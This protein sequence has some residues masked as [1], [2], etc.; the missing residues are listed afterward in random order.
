M[1][2]A[3]SELT[4]M[5]RLHE[6]LLAQFASEKSKSQTELTQAEQTIRTAKLQRESRIL[7]ATAE[8]DKARD[9]L[10]RCR[11]VAHVGAVT[12]ETMVEAETQFRLAQQRL[13]QAQL[14]LE[15][16]Q[17]A[18]LTAALETVDDDF[19]VRLAEL[20]VQKVA[21]EG[22]MDVAAKE[23][24]NLQ[25]AKTQA[26][27]RAPIDGVV[28]SGQIDVGDVLE[29]SKPAV[30]IAPQ[31]GFRFE[32]AVASSDVGGLEP[33]M[34]VK[35]KLDAYDYQKYGTL[36]GTVCFISPDSRVANNGTDE[37][38][39][40]GPLAYIL[41]V[42]LQDD[43]VGHGDLRGTVKL[44]LGGTAEIVAGRDSILA[45]LF[46]KIRRTISLG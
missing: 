35:I 17:V 9:R 44:G 46:K 18:V 37:A 8:L 30:E 21:K 31:G 28:V 12:D 32:V 5:N 39:A 41:R 16:G 24:A 15:E 42:E 33:G 14:P 34:P 36:D 45:I 13:T 38:P 22:E 43:E 2:T 20:S 10:E 4:E 6:L 19:D 26:T 23:L 3:N 29:R 40:A 25:L 1:E 11:R 27:L 7:E